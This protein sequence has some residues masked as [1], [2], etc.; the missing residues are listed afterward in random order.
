[1]RTI[2]IRQVSVALISL[3]VISALSFLLMELAPGDAMSR[4]AENP[5]ITRADRDVI[6]AN[7]GLDRP[8]HVRYFLWLTF[9]VRGDMGIS[10]MTG[11]PVLEEILSRMPATMK[12]MGLSLFISIF[13][14]VSLGVYS[15]THKNSFADN[16]ISFCSFIGISAPSFWLGLLM[17]YVFAYR[18]NFLPAGGYSTPW[19]DYSAYSTFARTYLALGEQIRYILMP[20][21]VLCISN[22]AI[23]SRYVRSAVWEELQKSYITTARAKGLSE[24]QI[25]YS[26]AL[27]NALTPMITMIGL[28]LPRIFAGSIVTEHIFAWPGMGRLFITA[29]HNRDYQVLMGIIMVTAVLVILGNLFANILYIRLNPRVR[30]DG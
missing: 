25:I 1:M 10:F 24:K 7:L 29:S 22:V 12:L 30:H 8:A 26:H 5:R 21:T 9:F 15:A 2:I 14:S 13:A 17:I 18:L 20:A 28:E 4:Y 27:R 11:R 16:F 6:A 19:F 3:L 23:W